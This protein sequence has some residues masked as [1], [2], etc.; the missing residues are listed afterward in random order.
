VSLRAKRGIGEGSK[1]GS[2][3]EPTV[4]FKIENII[5]VVYYV[6]KTKK[7]V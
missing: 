5:T 6:I 7:N 2:E 4:S 3:A 1:G